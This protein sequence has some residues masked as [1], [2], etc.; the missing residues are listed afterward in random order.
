[1]GWAPDADRAQALAASWRSATGDLIDDGRRMALAD[2]LLRDGAISKST[3]ASV[4]QV[5]PATASKHLSVL[6]ARGVLLQSG[7]GPATRYRLP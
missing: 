1:L 4:C 2:S 6:A 5:S 7:K 3:Y